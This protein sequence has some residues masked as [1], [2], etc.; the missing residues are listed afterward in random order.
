MFGG[1][2]DVV[3]DA[4]AVASALVAVA[5]VLY[6]IVRWGVLRPLDRR[7]R[8]ATRQI[9]PGANGGESLSDVAREMRA[10]ISEVEMMRDRF[11]NVE[12]RQM[13]ILEMVIREQSELMQLKRDVEGRQ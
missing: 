6:A 7:I 11:D 8:E 3:V 1:F 13:T 5:G 4:G 10:L 2:R 12:Q 9:Q